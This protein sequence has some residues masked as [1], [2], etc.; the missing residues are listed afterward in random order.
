MPQKHRLK[1]RKNTD[2][3]LRETH[4][5]R[6]S[7]RLR[8]PIWQEKG[9][10]SQFCHVKNGISGKNYR[11]KNGISGFP[12]ERMVLQKDTTDSNA[13]ILPELETV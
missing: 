13:V 1:C 11:I 3:S 4:N 12:T 2:W 7:Q 6:C 10:N 8:K 5:K 9:I